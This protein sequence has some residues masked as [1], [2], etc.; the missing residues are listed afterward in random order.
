MTLP[1][2]GAVVVAHGSSVVSH[3]DV[4]AQATTIILRQSEDLIVTDEIGQTTCRNGRRE[5]E[6]R[7]LSKSGDQDVDTELRHRFLLMALRSR[8]SA[9][10]RRRVSIFESK[11]REGQ[12]AELILFSLLVRQHGIV[13]IPARYPCCKENRPKRQKLLG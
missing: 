11:S 10:D 7:R 9:Q 5:G 1:K 2:D 6:D 4:Y 12:I 3:E 13:V 8:H